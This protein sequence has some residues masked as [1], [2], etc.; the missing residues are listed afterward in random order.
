MTRANNVSEMSVVEYCDYVEQCALYLGT[1]V[2]DLNMDNFFVRCEISLRTYEYAKWEL[3]RRSSFPITDA[4][5]YDN[6][7]T[8]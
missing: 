4:D 7:Y 1:D 3:H 2:H 5:D 8:A 6:Y